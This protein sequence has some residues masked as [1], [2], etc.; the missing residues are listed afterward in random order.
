M[1][2]SNDTNSPNNNLMGEK[3]Q[4]LKLMLE[5]GQIFLGFK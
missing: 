5:Y 1:I 4:F 2:I 3:Y